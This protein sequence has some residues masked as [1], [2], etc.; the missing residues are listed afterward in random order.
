MGARKRTTATILLIGALVGA[1][2]ASC[3]DAESAAESAELKPAEL[4]LAAAAP[5]DS[6]ATA[7]R[8]DLFRCGSTKPIATERVGFTAATLADLAG[9]EHKPVRLARAHLFGRDRWSLTPGCYLAKVHPLD[10]DGEPL[11]GCRPTETSHMPLGPDTDHH[12]L[13]IARCGE[14]PSDVASVDGQ[15]NF[16]PALAPLQVRRQANRVEICATA[17]DPEADHLQIRWRARTDSGRSV[18]LASTASEQA[19]ST[20]TACATLQRTSE[21]VEVT[22]TA[23]DGVAYVSGAFAS[24][25]ELRLHKFGVATPSRA[26]SSVRVESVVEPACESPVESWTYWIRRDGR[27]LPPTDELSK[28]RPG[29]TVEAEVEVREGCQ[30]T[31]IELASFDD[32]GELAER[33]GGT[34]GPGTHILWVDMPRSSFEVA[35]GI[36][37]AGETRIV[38]GGGQS[39]P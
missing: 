11:G 24:F 3:A 10:I 5:V 29:D 17:R 39:T 37:V 8:V 34:Y 35:L 13:M 25:E 14:M 27:S 18:D 28:V 21:P 9:F 30:D 1:A 31:K 19:G 32:T 23:Y 7:V 4:N 6:E 2:G 16:A 22:A 15:L 20:L 12:F 36:R 33:D 26:R 38:D